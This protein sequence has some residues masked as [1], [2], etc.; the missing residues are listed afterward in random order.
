MNHVK[1]TA[2]SRSRVRH[3][4]L[5]EEL[6]SRLNLKTTWQDSI[7][8]FLTSKFGSITFFSLNVIFFFVWVLINTGTL[9][10]V[11]IFDPYPFI[12]LTMVVSLE[13]ILLAIIVL[14]SQN[15]QSH[16]AYL[17]EQIDFEV[18]VRAEEEI[19]KM[20]VFQE[21]IA[22]HLNVPIVHD[23]ELAEMEDHT[24]IKRI[25]DEVERDNN[26]S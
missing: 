4:K 13:A 22:K 19:S 17:R 12:L 10:V 14:I 20:L 16:N 7:A 15:R 25:L 18:D 21:K 9:P 8:D 26:K 2:K 11:Q 3:E 1:G 24:D 23:A 6:K 5:R